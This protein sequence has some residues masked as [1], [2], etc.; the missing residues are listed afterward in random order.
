MR[1]SKLKETLPVKKNRVQGVRFKL[2]FKF[3][4]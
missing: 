3:H 1:A 2:T 4:A